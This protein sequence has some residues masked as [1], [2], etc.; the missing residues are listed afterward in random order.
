MPLRA[1]PPRQT[2]SETPHSAEDYEK[3][4]EREAT[5]RQ[6]QESLRRHKQRIRANVPIGAQFTSYIHLHAAAPPDETPEQRRKRLLLAYK[7]TY[8]RKLALRKRGL[9]FAD[10]S[11]PSSP[12]SGPEPGNQHLPIAGRASETSDELEAGSDRG[13]TRRDLLHEENRSG[14]SSDSDRK[15]N[16]RKRKYANYSQAHDA[17]L[18]GESIKQGRHRLK[19]NKKTYRRKLAQRKSARDVESRS[20]ALPSPNRPKGSPESEAAPN[21]QRGST[22]PPPPVHRGEILPNETPLQARKRRRTEAVRRYEYKISHA[23][24]TT[25][26]YDHKPASDETPEQRA[27]RQGRVYRTASG[28]RRGRSSGGVSPIPPAELPPPSSRKPPLRS[29][30]P[31]SAPPN[32]DTTAGTLLRLANTRFSSTKPP[33]APPLPPP[34]YAFQRQLAYAV[35]RRDNRNSR[36]RE[37][38]AAKKLGQSG[39][40]Q[41]PSKSTGA[42]RQRLTAE[43]PVRQTPSRRSRRQSEQRRSR[44]ESFGACPASENDNELP[45]PSSPPKS[46]MRPSPTDSPNFPA[47]LHIAK[48]GPTPAQLSKADIEPT[49]RSTPPV[50]SN[51]RLIQKGAVRHQDVSSVRRRP[52]CS[53]ALDVC[54]VDLR[55]TAQ[56]GLEATYEAVWE[57]AF[58]YVE[59]AIEASD[60]SEEESSRQL[61]ALYALQQVH[62]VQREKRE[63]HSHL[64]RVCG[65]LEDVVLPA[66]LSDRINEQ[67]FS[68]Q[69]YKSRNWTSHA[70]RE[71]ASVLYPVFEQLLNC[72]SHWMRHIPVTVVAALIE[73][74]VIDQEA[75]M[76]TWWWD[77]E[78]PRAVM[79]KAVQFCDVDST[80]GIRERTRA[81]FQLLLAVVRYST[82]FSGDCKL[83]ADNFPFGQSWQNNRYSEHNSSIVY[84]R[85]DEARKFI[86]I[87][88]KLGSA[89]EIP[90]I[91]IEGKL[92]RQKAIALGEL[93][94]LEEEEACYFCDERKQAIVSCATDMILD[95]AKV[96]NTIAKTAAGLKD[97]PQF[98]ELAWRIGG[99]DAGIVGPFLLSQLLSPGGDSMLLDATASSLGVAIKQKLSNNHSTGLIEED[100]LGDHAMEKRSDRARRTI[101]RPDDLLLPIV[102]KAINESGCPS[103]PKSEQI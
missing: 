45:E 70:T 2:T 33:P 43:T 46:N 80:S 67:M 51:P 30:P 65:E 38:Y 97:N 62:I 3:E 91:E 98:L 15:A 52:R 17:T 12:T 57:D 99:S 48:V 101:T 41:L 82:L 18:P 49:M 31:P 93:D 102:E 55:D 56:S 27:A 54:D 61:D 68:L 79:S 94:D 71:A 69:G 60:V 89:W 14:S 78:G 66:M 75:S 100:C 40:M 85:V 53:F 36:R 21:T 9:K 11:P 74:L 96:L 13:D 72:P 20:H 19:E 50:K 37:R 34:P 84:M 26:R 8:R 24:P 95:L 23:I 87:L 35:F 29:L 7:N 81:A 25:P 32:R 44:R 90:A 28:L 6:R 83:D 59:S 47:A 4:S 86:M 63:K 77:R 1:P 39:M 73:A 76:P 10:P 5:K 16:T 88:H 42:R 64:G 22:P 92:S 58:A 103:D